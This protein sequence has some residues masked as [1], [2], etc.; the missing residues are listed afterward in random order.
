MPFVQPYDEDV[1]A[2]VEVVLK[3]GMTVT[4]LYSYHEDGDQEEKGSG[5]E[6]DDD[7]DDDEYG[8]EEGELTEEQ[9]DGKQADLWF[10]A[11]DILKLL[12]NVNEDGFYE[13]MHITTGTL[14]VRGWVGE[15]FGIRKG[16]ATRW[17]ACHCAHCHWDVATAPR[18]QLPDPNSPIPTPRAQLPVPAAAPHSP[19][20]HRVTLRFRCH[21]WPLHAVRTHATRAGAPNYKDTVI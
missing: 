19:L 9:Q 3:E 2:A 14:A 17:D 5:G 16:V 1:H 18:S 6:H 15:G 7:D 11:G 8:E 13:A 21:P 20:R 12:S 10:A 4:C